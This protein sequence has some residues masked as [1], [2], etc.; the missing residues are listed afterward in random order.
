[1]FVAPACRNPGLILTVDEEVE[2]PVI[3]FTA[4]FIGQFRET[5]HRCISVKCVWSP[6]QSAWTDVGFSERDSCDG[7]VIR[8][9]TLLCGVHG[10]EQSCLPVVARH[11]AHGDF[12]HPIFP[13]E[14]IQT[15]ESAATMGGSA[16]PAFAR[17]ITSA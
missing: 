11:F 1:M 16:S 10:Q 7:R 13:V 8:Y 12:G 17:K 5:D 2:K 15:C 14:T 9:E 4:G 3:L 6:Y